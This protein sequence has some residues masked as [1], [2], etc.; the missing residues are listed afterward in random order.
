MHGTQ[1]NRASVN[2]LQSD[3]ECL[4][5]ELIGHLNIHS[6]SSIWKKCIAAQA[7]YQ[8][9]LIKIDAKK[10][11]YCDGAGI[12]L[13]SEIKTRQLANKQEC[14]IENLHSKP[15]KLLEMILNKEAAVSESLTKE[16][17][18]NRLRYNLGYFAADIVG[19][20]RENIQFV[21]KLCVEIYKTIIHPLT[22]RWKDMWKAAQQVGPNGLP[23]NAGLG[24][25]IG[26]ISAFQAAITLEKFGAQIYVGSL[27]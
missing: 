24:F 26:L 9:R 17:L 21:G 8:P 14:N 16:K 12:A 1:E 20:I 4:S 10:L 23:I 22:I 5:I 18:S 2:F 19:Q 27:V 7:K 13:L 15:K 6:A 3:A 25:L 11:D